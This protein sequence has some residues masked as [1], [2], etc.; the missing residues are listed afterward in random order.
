MINMLLMLMAETALLL[1]YFIY[2][3]EIPD[4]YVCNIIS[5]LLDSRQSQIL[6][7][8]RSNVADNWNISRRQLCVS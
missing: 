1:L 3:G 6:M 5:N 7:Y 2:S 4:R 8:V